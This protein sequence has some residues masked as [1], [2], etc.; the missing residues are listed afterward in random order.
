MST[1]ITTEDNELESE[2]V[3]IMGRASYTGAEVETRT[4]DV[5]FERAD[6]EG[7]LWEDD[8]ESVVSAVANASRISAVESL[9]N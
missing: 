9:K 2:I 8:F 1:Q 5:M 3:E 4:I 7:S 6:E